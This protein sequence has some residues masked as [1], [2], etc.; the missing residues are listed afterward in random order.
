MEV[1]IPP[2]PGSDQMPALHF[3]R[4]MSQE[5]IRGRRDEILCALDL[6]GK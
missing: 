3:D 6:P 2:L 1:I 4:P 5:Y